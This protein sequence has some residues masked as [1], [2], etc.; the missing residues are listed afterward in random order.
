MNRPELTEQAFLSLPASMCS[1][2]GQGKE[3]IYRT[4]DLAR[5]ITQG[6]EMVE[7]LGRQDSQVKIRGLRVELGQIEVVVQRSGLVCENAH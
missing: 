1:E 2:A 3:M 4:G 5:R 7:L 6:Q